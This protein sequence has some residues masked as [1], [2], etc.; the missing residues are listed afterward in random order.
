M[1]LLLAAALLLPACAGAGPIRDRIYHPPTAPLSLEGLP[2][3]ATLSR[4]T[5]A[6]G[7]AL[8]GVELPGRPDR[9]VVLVLHG[10]AGDADGALAWLAPLAARGYG[11]VAAEY[12]GY[13]ANPGRPD[14][15]GLARDAD[16]FYARARVLAG[17]RPVIVLGHSL[18]GG[19]AFGLAGRERLDALVTLG[20]FTR[21]RAMAPRIARA[22]VADRYDNVATVPSLD[23]PW[24]LIHGT[25]DDVV[26]PQ[27]GNALHVAAAKAH[28]SG[29]SLVLVGADH[30]PAGALVAALVDRVAAALA[31]APAPPLPDGVRLDPFR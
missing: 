7:L 25:A 24:W 30:H 6:D 31:H 4:V 21:L 8:T 3:G 23:E 27:M 22:L 29:E 9:P 13:S 20:T 26:P 16:A 15:R 5:T 17:T 10:N 14:E 2:G 12:R 11:V 1:R 19:V 28:R 18:G